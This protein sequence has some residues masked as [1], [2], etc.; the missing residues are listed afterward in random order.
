VPGSVFLAL[1]L[2]G[3]A[4]SPF[5][6]SPGTVDPAVGEEQ[7]PGGR[8][9]VTAT[10]RV[11]S[12]PTVPP[13]QIRPPAPDR[14]LR[15][16]GLDERETRALLGAPAEVTEHGPAQVWRYPAETCVLEIYFYYDVERDEF[17]VLQ[18]T[19]AEAEPSAERDEQ[20]LRT[21]DRENRNQ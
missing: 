13:P 20:C 6:P 11:A 21:I 8:E 5:A 2:S 4:G 3:C 16:V 7:T 10:S 12:I 17:F 9:Y 18:Y 19:A 15:L 1:L 14:D